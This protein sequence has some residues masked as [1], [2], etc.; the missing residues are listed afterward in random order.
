M[1]CL[2]LWVSKSSDIS[3]QQILTLSIL[4]I[5]IDIYPSYIEPKENFK[6]V[7]TT[8][9]NPYAVTLSRN[10]TKC[11]SECTPIS[12]SKCDWSNRT[13]ETYCEENKVIVYV[14]PA[15]E[16]DFTTWTCSD[17]GGEGDE[18]LQRFGK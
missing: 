1:S 13:P 11:V 15:M 2:I 16:D 9:R 10:N 6:I 7:C 17:S 5:S 4:G 18:I 8:V 3:I 14:S 12:D